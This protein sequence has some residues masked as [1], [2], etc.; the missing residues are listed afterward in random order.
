MNEILQPPAVWTLEIDRLYR[1][2]DA[3]LIVGEVNNG[4]ELVG[5]LLTGINRALPFKAV[6]ASRGK[7]VRAE[8]VAALYERGIVHHAGTFPDLEEQMCSYS[9]SAGKKSPDRMDALVWALT[10]L[11]AANSGENKFFFA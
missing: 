8:P 6:R 11:S 9:A 10:E 7:I 5:A 3:D 1:E 4:G 2:L